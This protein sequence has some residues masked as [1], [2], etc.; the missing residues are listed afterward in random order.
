MG[1]R[2]EM[3]VEGNYTTARYINSPTQVLAMCVYSPDKHILYTL[4]DVKIR[5]S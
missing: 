1:E 4:L 5:K 2:E 3:M